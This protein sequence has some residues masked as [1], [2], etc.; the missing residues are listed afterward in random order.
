MSQYVQTTGGIILSAAE[1][2]E[3]LPKKPEGREIASAGN[4]RDITRGYLPDNLLMAAGDTVLATRGNGDY[5]IYEEIARDDQVKTCRQQR[6]LALIAK[7]WGVEPGDSS[8]K[9]KKAADRLEAFLDRLAWDDK[10]QKM[11]S[12][13]LYGFA[14][15]EVMWATDGLE[16]TIDD[17]KVRNRSRFG[18]LP[19]G[20]LRLRTMNN[21]LDGEALPPGKFWAFACGADHDD[22]PY[23]LGLGH[24]LYW[25]VF[26]KK[27]GIKFWLQFLEK[28][29]QPTAVGKYPAGA[30]DPEKARL[31]Q[32]L[33]AIQSSTAIRIPEGMAIELLEATRSGTADYTALYD[34][35]NA[36]ISK[37]YLGHSAGADSTPG[38]LGGED[39]AGEVREDLIK[40]DADLICGSFNRTV[41][42]WLTWYNDGEG[43]APPRVWRKTEPPEDLQ[44]AASK[45]KTLFDMG[46]KPTITYITDK[47]GEGYEENANVGALQTENQNNVGRISDSVTRQDNPED[48]AQPAQFAEG[49]D[50]DP[51]GIDSQTEQLASEAGASVKAMLDQI[52]AFA[53]QAESLE[54]LRDKL[55]ASYGE[56]D[57]EKLTNVMA[58]GFAA[59][60]L[61]GR[62]DV[63]GE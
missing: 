24:Y 26:F 22:E 43:V 36:A 63:E 37:V 4:G 30:S 53:E 47:Y 55:L 46:F 18:F 13:V 40:A 19:S 45:D 60:E 1:F 20:E 56:L 38:K 41:A 44:A 58:M 8:R 21:Q 61:S 9:A 31:L 57:S 49:D 12:G 17:I 5:K 27:N 59:A 3:T 32:A 10:T 39:N 11:L 50:I 48:P 14:V 42:K 52:A 54:A 62:F 33:S 29:G 35:M 25:P 6:E 7:E 15:G 23:G 2:A 51:T 16:I 28:F 34:R